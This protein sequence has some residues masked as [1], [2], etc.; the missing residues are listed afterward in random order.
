MNQGNQQANQPNQ[1]NQPANQQQQNQANQQ[2]QV[3][4][5]VPIP[6]VKK[7]LSKWAIVGLDL[8]DAGFSKLHAKESS[9]SNDKVKYNLEPEKFEAYKNDLIEK[10]NRMHSIECLSTLDDTNNACF[11][12]KEYTKLTLDNIDEARELRWPGTDPIFNTQEEA[13]RFT[14]EQLK[15]SCVGSYIHSSLT[16]AAKKQLRAQ[17]DLFTVKD[18]ENNEFFDGPSYFW[19]LAD[20]V[21]PDNSHMIENVRKNLRSLNVKDF[22]FSII[23]MLAEYK[24]LIQRI[25][26]LGG[27]YDE[28]DQFIDFW[29]CLRTHKEKEFAR[30]VRQEKDS[31][32]KLSRA[33]RGNIEGY[34]RDFSK[35]EISMK[36]DKEWN[37]MS[38]EDAMILALVNSIDKSHVSKSKD[39][40]KTSN[41]DKKNNATNDK[42]DKNNLTDKE[43]LER[44]EAKIPDWKKQPPKSGE[45]KSK[46]V[47]EKKYYWCQKCR[48]GNGLWALH[49]THND[50]FSYK[51]Y[52][53]KDE[54]SSG[55]KKVSFTS[56]TKTSSNAKDD[57][58]S[59]TVSKGLLKNCKAY[60]AQFE[61]FQS[62]GTQS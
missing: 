53:K 29:D 16:E 25:S 62:G 15:T 60:L 41:S 18:A 51:K 11:I 12:P 28:D 27:T 37:V 54:K 46:V 40:K 6:I 24:T 55:N 39:K 36:E 35:K 23:K 52:E 20:I 47:G 26:E 33:N 31:Y 30:Y 42:H 38:P 19:N 34:I 5:Q 22:G 9:F 14:D 59:V 21:D 32:R 44:K 48:S 10:I 3:Q 2:Q 8:Q 7:T 49:E 45:D 1:P 13:D 56:N 43:K 57:E 58:P 50:S 61:D 17:Q 4:V